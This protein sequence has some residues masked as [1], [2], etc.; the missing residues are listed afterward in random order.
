MLPP[1]LHHLA[2]LGARG[3][4]WLL[5][6]AG[7]AALPVAHDPLTLRFKDDVLEGQYRQVCLWGRGF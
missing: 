6:R 5:E 7:L 1:L 2:C 3:A 4:A